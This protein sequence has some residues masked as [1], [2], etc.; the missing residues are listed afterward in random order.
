MGK[1]R[2]RY[3][4][5]RRKHQNLIAD[6]ERGFQTMVLYANLPLLRRNT[7]PCTLD[8]AKSLPA[9]RLNRPSVAFADQLMLLEGD[10]GPRCLLVEIVLNQFGDQVMRIK[11]KEKIPKARYPIRLGDE[12]RRAT[13]LDHSC[14]H[15]VMGEL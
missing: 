12:V 8:L 15:D 11:S 7:I 10:D 2:L 5:S 6:S 4:S 13:T 3:C 9:V 14:F 1:K